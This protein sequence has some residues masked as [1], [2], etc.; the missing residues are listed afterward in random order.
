MERS[1]ESWHRTS[2]KDGKLATTSSCSFVV[3]NRFVIDAKVSLKASRGRFPVAGLHLI[4]RRATPATRQPLLQRRSRH[5]RI[6]TYCKT[7]PTANNTDRHTCHNGPPAVKRCWSGDVQVSRRTGPCLQVNI[8]WPV[9][10]LL[11]IYVSDVLIS[12]HWA[13]TSIFRCG[14]PAVYVTLRNV[15]L[16]VYKPKSVVTATAYATQIEIHFVVVTGCW[17]GWTPKKIQQLRLFFSRSFDNLACWLSSL[18][19]L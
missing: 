7:D 14:S 3:L 11:Q 2:G 9:R 13:W 19:S 1:R 5:Q 10:T 4:G 6:N 18:K 8:S 17:V 12:R 15:K 16:L